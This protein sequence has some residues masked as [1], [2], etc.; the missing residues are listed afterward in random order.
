MKNLFFKLHDE[1]LRDDIAEKA[2]EMIRNGK[3]SEAYDLRDIVLGKW[4]GKEPD[5]FG[6][7]ISV[8]DCVGASFYIT[9]CMMGDNEDSPDTTVID[10]ELFTESLK[11]PQTVTL[12]FKWEKDTENRY[13]T[14]KL[15]FDK[16]K[17][18]HASYFL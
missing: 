10:S 2:F 9:A 7:G 4:N 3:C 6:F 18:R 12:E 8:D 13:K 14:I 16:I 15:H 5:D 17:G 11:I 1:K